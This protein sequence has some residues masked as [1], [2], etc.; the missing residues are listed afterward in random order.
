MQ[1]LWSLIVYLPTLRNHLD[2]PADCA[3]HLGGHGVG[4]LTGRL[5]GEPIIVHIE[6]KSARARA[7]YG[8]ACPDGC[9]E[10]IS[11]FAH[12]AHNVD[13]DLLAVTHSRRVSAIHSMAVEAGVADRLRILTFA[14]VA[15][16]IENALFVDGVPA[17]DLVEA[18]L[19]VESRT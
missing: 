13:A 8:V 16:F 2:I 17:Q 5:P 6:I 9:G 12:M 18:L 15:D 1:L 4:D 3:W 19:D 14:E 11:Q 7:S 10:Y